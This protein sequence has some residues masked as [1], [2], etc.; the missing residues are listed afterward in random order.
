[1]PITTKTVAV[2]V[3]LLLVTG[4]TAGWFSRAP[5]PEVAPQPEVAFGALLSLS[6]DWSSEGETSEAAL[7]LAVKDVNEYLSCIGSETSIKLIVED[8][9]TD[10]AVALEKLKSLKEKGVRVV[11][12]PQT[13]AEVEAVKAY[14]DKNGILLVSQSSTAPSLAIPGDNVFRLCPD[15]THQAEAIAKLMWD[16]GVRAV[17]P[18]WRGDVW[19]D[20]L[21]EATKSSFE[22][23]GGTVID[24]VRYSPTTEDFSAELESLNLKVSQAIAQYGADAVGVHLIAFEEVV[25]IF[26]QAGEQKAILSTVKWY[27]SDGTAL[28]KELVNN[29][30]AAQFAVRTGFP[31]PIYAIKG[32]EE[33]TEKHGLVVEQIQEKI[34]RTPDAYALAAYDALWVATQA[35]LATG[36]TNDPNALK[37][38]FMQTASSYVGTTGWT[39]LNEAGDVK[40]DWDYDFWAATAREEKGAFQWVRVARYEVDPGVP[41]QLIYER[42]PSL[43]PTLRVLVVNSYHK[44]MEWEQDIQKGIVKGLSRAGYIESQDYELKTFCMDTKVTYTTPE[45]IE[46]RAAIAL[47]LIDE[48]KPDIVFA[49]NDNALKY[50]A[51]EY[52]KRHPEKKLPFVFSGVNLNPTV[53]KPIESLEMPGGPITGALERVPYYEAF[54]LG[55]RISLSASKIVLLADPSPSSTL[56]VS[57]FKERYQD[58]V[59]DSPLEVIDY[60]QVETFKEWKEKVAEYQTK[61]DFIGVLNYHQLRAENG[62]VVPAP[63]VIDWTIHNNKL[64]ELGLIATYAEDGLLAA[65]G[66][67]YY[68]TGIYVGV[69]GGEI[70]AGSDPATIPIVDPKAVDIAFNLER[71]EMLG[72]KISATE[73]VEADE[74]HHPI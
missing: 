59:T 26:T 50:V 33:E 15:D 11:I 28:D 30:R 34:W 73:L 68:K 48:F 55:K 20:D 74:V 67:S 17:I 4:F 66:V 47:D 31:N 12:G 39:I 21:A 43:V 58:K 3:V 6:G 8:T 70:L 51:V 29:A 13:S 10:P 24:G 44:G 36:G 71:A 32:W 38:A 45:Q 53:Y 40:E 35:Y 42:K 60:I 5:A 22:A 72:M 63:E 69:V 52:T 57:A 46:Q 64:P 16:A 14:A 61:A 19:G 7:E 56:A 49:N 65:T 9:E 23:L 27:G 41:G 2:I 62:E 18:I 54:S 1:M 25:T 37:K